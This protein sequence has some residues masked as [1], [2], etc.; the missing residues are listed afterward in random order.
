MLDLTINDGTSGQI[1]STNGSG[2]FTF[3]D[4][5]NSTTYTDADARN[6][7]FPLTPSNTGL[8]LINNGLN[9]FDNNNW[10]NSIDGIARLRFFEN[11][12]TL[13]NAP[14][15]GSKRIALKIGFIDKLQ[16]N[17]TNIISY[18]DIQ[19]GDGTGS[20]MSLFLWGANS[21]TQSSTIVFNDSGTT[22]P[23]RNG[24]TINYNS[25]QNRLEFS[26]DQNND[27]YIDNPPIL[28][29][30]RETKRVGIGISSPSGLLHIAKTS[31]DNTIQDQL[32]LECHNNE[33][34]KGNAILFKNRWNNG[35]YWGMARIKA[36]EESG[37]GGALI[38]ETNNGSG[39][40]DTT[41]VEAMRIDEFGNIGIGTSSPTFKLDVNGNFRVNGDLRVNNHF[42]IYGTYTNDAVVRINTQA[43]NFNSKLELA[44]P[45]SGSI[46]KKAGVVLQAIGKTEWGN[47]DFVIGISNT[48]NNSKFDTPNNTIGQRLRIYH[49]SFTELFGYGTTET[50]NM[51][52]FEYNTPLYNQSAQFSDCCLKVNGSI[53]ST[54]WI[55]S[56]SSIKIKKDIEDLNDKECLDKLLLLQPKKYRYIDET[57]NFDS[58]K[59]VYGF[60]AEDVK[61]IIP[62]A[63]DDTTPCLIPNIYLK[64]NV[65]GN[66]LTLDK[67][68]ELNIEYKSYI[69]INSE[70]A[71]DII[72]IP[73]EKLSENTYRID[74]EINGRI[75]VYGKTEQKFNSLKKEYFHAITISAVQELH[76]T[77]ERQQEQINT[78]IEILSRNSIT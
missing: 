42:M 51:K 35:A 21:K 73:L 75:F 23:Y 58:E 13:I 40:A 18:N 52:Y 69:E 20:N 9:I 77:I 22:Q 8:E 55:G 50:L 17:D 36:I 45:S 1:L 12:S 37:Y 67:E 30:T 48:T 10:Y 59:K 65:V 34:D 26:G 11:D 14:N 19:I 24:M 61:E 76:R 70:Q 44:T 57:K 4:P 6:A 31:I 5:E 53:L 64:G 72:I 7:C 62:E 49:D 71:I 25:L 16:I 32:I 68:L 41:T 47:A 29:L 46:S 60:I 63:V 43:Y 39:Y 74:K 33:G 27:T 78:L 56:S 28:T 66:I 38:F 54:S 3:I 2:T 15:T